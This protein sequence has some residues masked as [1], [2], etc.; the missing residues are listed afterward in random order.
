MYTKVLVY[1]NENIAGLLFNAFRITIFLCDLI[2]NNNIKFSPCAI[3]YHPDVDENFK[4][5][6]KIFTNTYFQF[7]L[8]NITY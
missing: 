2:F 6:C 5:D 4:V 8:I 7:H 1:W 3:S